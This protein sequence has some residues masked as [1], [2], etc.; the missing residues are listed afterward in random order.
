MGHGPLVFDVLKADAIDVASRSPIQMGTGCS[1]SSVL[2]MMMGV[3]DVGSMV[4]PVML[5]HAA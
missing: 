5:T 3:L 1:S 4:K 2:R